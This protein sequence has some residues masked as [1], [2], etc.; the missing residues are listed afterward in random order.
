MLAYTFL[1][2]D[3]S[4]NMGDRMIVDKSLGILSEKIGSGNYKNTPFRLK[5]II[6]GNK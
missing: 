1:L 6:M 3:S 4:L 5:N 2:Y